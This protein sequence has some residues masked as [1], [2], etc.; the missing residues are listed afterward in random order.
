MSVTKKDVGYFARIIGVLLVITM[1]VALLLSC[2]NMIT[3]DRIAANEKAK[4]QEAI[5]KLYPD[6]EKLSYDKLNVSLDTKDEDVKKA[7]TALYIVKDDGNEI[8]YYAEVAPKGFNGAIK[9]L[10]GITLDGKISGI[11]IITHGETVGIGDKI[12]DKSFRGGFNGLTSTEEADDI[13]VITGA[14]YS[15]KAVKVGVKTALCAYSS[16]TGGA[17][18]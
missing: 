5:E 7:F 11:Q 14:T 8:G 17:E 3:K 13:D 1:F 4:L 9:M 16:Y 2:V 10:I 15:S 18:Q 12:E 6:K